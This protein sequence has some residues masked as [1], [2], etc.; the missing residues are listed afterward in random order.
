MQPDTP[1]MKIRQVFKEQGSKQQGANPSVRPP[2]A[3]QR[4]PIFISA[5]AK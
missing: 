4:Q 3:F 2:G 5:R 1:Q